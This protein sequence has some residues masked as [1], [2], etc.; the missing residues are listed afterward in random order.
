MYTVYKIT[1][2]KNGKVYIGSTTLLLKTRW[3][4]HVDAYKNANSQRPLY[5]DMRRYGIDSFS[6]EVIETC[7]CSI[8]LKELEKQWME[9]L[10]CFIPNGYNKNT[11]RLPKY[12]Q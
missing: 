7:D 9:Q 10:N 6:V 5:K 1:N 11:V 8:R 12:H 3:N 2:L 4:V